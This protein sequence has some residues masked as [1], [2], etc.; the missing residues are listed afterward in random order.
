MPIITRS[1]AGSRQPLDPAASSRANPPGRVSTSRS[2]LPQQPSSEGDVRRNNRTLGGR[3]SSLAAGNERPPAVRVRTCR[4]DCLSCPALIRTKEIESYIT[5]RKY[6]VLDIDP[7]LIS[8]KLQ[9]YI[10]LLTCLSCYVP[11]VGESVIVINKRM[12][13]HRRA[14]SGCTLFINHYNNVCPGASF[15]I[16][17]L[18]KL[19]GNGYLN[20]V[21]DEKM[22]EYRL[23]RE[24]YWMKKLRTVYPYGLNDRTKF[25]NVDA[26]VGHLFPALPRYG[27]K[28]LEQ[29]SRLNRNLDNPFSELDIFVEHVN[30]IDPKSRGNEVRKLL[31]GFKQKH[32][33]SL[34]AE[35]HK[36]LELNHDSNFERLYKLLVDT[37]LTKV[38]KKPPDKKQ[39]PKH[40]LPIYFDNK[41]L[42]HIKLSSILHEDDV[43]N[44]L[45]SML[46]HQ[47]SPSVVYSLSN[48]IHSKLFNYKEAVNSIDT[49][50]TETH[51]TGITTCDCQYSEFV[52]EHH[53]HVVTGD[54]RIIQN[55]KLRKLISKGPNYREPRTINWKRCRDNIAEGLA[56]CAS[57]MTSSCKGLRVEDMLPWQNIVLERVEAK[58]TSLKRKIKPHKTNPVLKQPDVIQYLEELHLK[59]V[60]VP[61]DKAANNV[62]IICKK[63]YIDVILKEVGSA[64]SDNNTYSPSHK[65][66]DEIIF[67]NIQYSKKLGLKVDEK[68]SDLPV[69]YWTPKMHK[70]PSG[71]R[72]IIASKHCSTKSLSKSVSTVFKLI[73][74]QVEKFHKNAKFLSNY[75]K[76]WVLQ[77]SDPIIDTLKNINRKKRAKSIAT[78]DFST[79]YTKLPHDKLI[80]QLS[81]VIDLVF[82]G[83]DKHFIR[84][85]DTGHAFWSKRKK[86]V[87][88]SKASLKIAV[89]H[90]I[91]NCYFTVGNLVTKQAI[92]IPMG[93]DPAP[94]WAN[95]F[96]Y[97]YEEEYISN[98]IPLH[99]VK[100]RHFHSTKRF[101]DDLC[102]INDG[103]EFGR[104]YKDIYPEE[105]ELK[106]EH[107]GHHASFLNLDITIEDGLFVYKLYDKRDTFPFHIVRMPQMSSNIPQSIFYSALVGE[108][109]RIARSTLLIR[110]FTPKAKELIERMKK[111]G[112]HTH[113]SQRFLR[114]VIVN[115]PESFTQFFLSPQELVQT[116]T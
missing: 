81:K 54:L 51:G 95:L 113:V 4:S 94:F 10:Y 53:G 58:I 2:E 13:I 44:K 16:Q 90:L 20:G 11:Y 26:P 107:S 78:Y 19:P 84:V 105:L 28:Y 101:I 14:K 24:D 91:E 89:S 37:F 100:A 103:G 73:F 59:Y 72:F 21:V 71:C 112:A 29:R 34:A 79:L 27:D 99:P 47:E 43:V 30:S 31:D 77:N 9:N 106:I 56:E 102:A 88:F 35:A 108:F 83:G 60:L 66:M 96:L 40:I 50:D 114:K 57:R 75:N 1:Q 32:L 5:G 68:D 70:T 3:P 98:I 18:E 41:G 74:S 6:T 48:T 22:R 111:Q 65:S 93:I 55:Q 39:A 67:D 33:K 116:I 15:S 92:G 12:N 85:T 52:N 61:I 25:M 109:L 97:T 76:F 115:H 49:N 17:I 45:P 62:A 64:T 82:K 80:F 104:V 8:C 69:M 63:H 38:Y 87:S 42:E 23:K 86:G 36:R 46:Q 110:D 7:N